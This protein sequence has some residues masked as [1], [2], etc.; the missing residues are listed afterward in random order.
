MGKKKKQDSVFRE[1][2]DNMSEDINKIMPEKLQ[3]KQG[4]KKFVLW[5]F[6]LEVVVLGVIGKLVYNWLSK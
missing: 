3:G 5:L 6:L 4:K 2:W 1:A